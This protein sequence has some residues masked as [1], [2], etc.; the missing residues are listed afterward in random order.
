MKFHKRKVAE[1]FNDY[2][3]YIASSLVEKL[4][5]CSRRFGD[6]RVIDCYHKLNVSDNIFGLFSVI[7]EHIASMLNSITNYSCL[8]ELPARLIEDG[9]SVIARLLIHIVNTYL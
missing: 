5:P 6:A 4:P 7:V 1:Y 2:F 9:S 8:D 3:I